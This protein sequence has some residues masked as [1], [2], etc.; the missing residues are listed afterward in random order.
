MPFFIDISTFSSI[1]EKVC[2]IKILRIS[3]ISTS[4]Y[5]K[6]YTNNIQL[7]TYIIHK[8][9]NV[10]GNIWKGKYEKKRVEIH[11]KKKKETKHVKNYMIPQ[12]KQ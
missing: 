6:R 8:Y 10:I 5:T 1:F 3:Y 11:M 4:R 2:L 12:K 9:T 7:F